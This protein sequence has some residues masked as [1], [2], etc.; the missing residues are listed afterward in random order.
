MWQHGSKI[1]QQEGEK[2]WKRHKGNK[3]CLLLTLTLPLSFSSF[4][5]RGP[6]RVSG[7]PTSVCWAYKVTKV[8]CW[9]VRERGGRHI[10]GSRST[11]RHPAH[12]GMGRNLA[13]SLPTAPSF[14]LG[15]GQLLVSIRF[16]NTTKKRAQSETFNI[17][18]NTEG[19]TDDWRTQGDRKSMNLRIWWILFKV[20]TRLLT[21]HPANCLGEVI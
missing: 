14:G 12:H 21:T 1:G 15:K 8:K 11:L 20:R 3:L 6:P 13:T 4:L 2:G 10:G 17:G 5:P 18:W 7:N 16:M 9:S 19:L